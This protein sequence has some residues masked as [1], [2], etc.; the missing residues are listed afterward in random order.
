MRWLVSA[1]FLAAWY[2]PGSLCAEEPHLDLVRGLRVRGMADLALDYLQRLSANPPPSVR[3]ILPLEIAKTRMELA[4]GESNERKRA[5]RIDEARVAY[6]S[7]VRA[8]PNH[9]LV[10]EAT[11]DLARLVAFQGKHLLAQARRADDAPTRS[12]LIKRARPLF[13]DAAARLAAA[14]T[15]ID[16]IAART[17]DPTIK[18]TLAQAKLQ[19][20]LESGINRLHVALTMPDNSGVQIKARAAEID[21]ARAALEVLATGSED[22]PFC[23]MARLWIARC[24]DEL[25]NNA[26]ARRMYESLAEETNPAAEEAARTA[27]FLLLKAAAEDKQAP[28]RSEQLKTVT[29]GLEDWLLKY[30]SKYSS[31][32]EQAA[33]YLLA[34][35]L[36]ELALAGVERD[37]PGT[38]TK[39]NAGVAQELARVER[40]LKQ[41]ADADGDYAERARNRRG[42]ILVLLLGERAAGDVSR[43]VNFEE[44][45]LAAQVQAFQLTQGKVAGEDRAKSYSRIAALLR[46]ALLLAGRADSARDVADARAM[47]AYTYLASGDPYAAAVYGEHVGKSKLAGSRSPEVTAYA[48]QAYSTIIALGRERHETDEQL[49]PDQRRL[50]Q[51]AQYMEKTWP[52]EV[53]TDLARHQLG[54]FLLDDHNYVEACAMW[55]RIAPS[56]P[57]VA[58]A[59]YQQGA[60]AQRAQ[61]KDVTL[62]PDQK[63]KLLRDAIAGL[64]QLPEPSPGGSDNAA[65][66]LCMAK[67][68]LG[69]LYLYDDSANGTNFVRAA[70]LGRRLADVIP[71]L[72]LDD[73]VRPQVLVEANKLYLA[74]T[75]NRAFLLVQADQTDAARTILQPIYERV[76]KEI[77][78][79]KAPEYA[80]GPWLEGYRE[81]QRQVIALNLRLAIQ[82]NQSEAAHQALTLLRRASG[83]ME[84]TN[85]RLLR[86]VYDLK[87]E[88]DEHKKKGE[89][90]KRDKLEKGLVSFLDELAKPKSLADD[91]RMF[92]AQAYGGLDR[93]DRAADLLAGYPAPANGSDEQRQRYHGVRLM[94]AREHRLAQQIDSAKTVLQEILGSWGKNDLSVRREKVLLLEDAGNYRDAVQE[95]RE[96]K[97]SLL[98]ARIDYDRAVRDEKLADEAERA[99]KTD[100]ARQKAAQDR[101]TAQ[102]KKNGTQTL[103]DRYWEFDFYDTRIVLRSC[104]K[105]PDP[106]TRDQKIAAV[107]QNIRRLEEAYPDVVGKELRDQYLSLFEIEPV[108]KA[109]YFEADGKVLA[110]S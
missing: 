77:E 75:Q 67:C 49:K 48:L 62:S 92:L 80:G 43:L 98:Q 55:G 7:F 72:S 24:L 86:L 35:L 58:Q 42:A 15:Q 19:A 84:N 108:L 20:Q 51:L 99:A 34:V 85:D 91:V 9:P 83:Q 56:Y 27:S 74:G 68:Q 16:E 11:L 64:E 52:D 65:L 47:L 70:E 1:V 12:D 6:D 10:A 33:Q 89:N 22:S 45:F 82:E 18:K 14:A 73:E 28:K 104:Q 106:A 50:R 109:K 17:E 21:T 26:E 87:R 97:R 88:A 107:A 93:H 44:C 53:A 29:T 76:R 66:A 110:S 30:R 78:S 100:D 5:R 41:I 103:R 37:R 105:V 2:Q 69:N 40:L 96:I 23:W 13:A 3:P 94:L 46:R 90:E 31:A 36:E 60:A 4:V 81:V 54:T 71:N 61:A 8:D 59:R 101:A 63:R 57:G 102:A 32:D 79:A 38:P 25:D 39:I 95:C